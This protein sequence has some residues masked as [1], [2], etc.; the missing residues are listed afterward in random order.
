MARRK[1]TEEDFIRGEGTLYI[2]GDVPCPKGHQPPY[3]FLSNGGCVICNREK[4]EAYRKANLAQ[5]H[6]R[7]KKTLEKPQSR[8]RYLLSKAKLRAKQ[9]NITYCPQIE[10]ALLS[11]IPTVC[12]VCGAKFIWS[13]GGGNKIHG[14]SL[15][16]V[17]NSEG[18]TPGNV[19]IICTRCNLI[20]R[21]GT[22]EDHEQIAAYIR[23]NKV[24]RP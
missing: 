10:S 9:T 24:I 4:V 2:R 17:N 15:D 5:A 3:R 21:D 18:Y 23:R 6:T 8:L 7:V 22:A 16:R 20:K 14:P 13:L 11:D 19:K 12:E 1:L